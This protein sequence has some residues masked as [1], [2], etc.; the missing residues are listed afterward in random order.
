MQR[1]RFLGLAVAAAA[2]GAVMAGG[3]AVYS[4]P[5]AAFDAAKRA[6]EKDDVRGFCGVL[7]DETRDTIAGGLLVNAAFFTRELGPK[8][9]KT[10]DEKAQLKRVETILA[11]HGFTADALQAIVTKAKELQGKDS[12]EVLPEVVKWLKPARD[13]CAL[14]ADLLALGGKEKKASPLTDV[15]NSRLDEVKVE[16]NVARGTVLI[17]RDDKENTE[18]IEFR[19]QGGGWRIHLDLAP[20][21]T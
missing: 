5:Q 18:P 11:R 20:K 14:V 16:G 21:K 3:S 7:D 9:A 4:T 19:K 6:A 12:A 13:R 8:L 15:K 1:S 10:D 2:A 17:K